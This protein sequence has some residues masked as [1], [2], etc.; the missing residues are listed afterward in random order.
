MLLYFIFNV[1]L[2]SLLSTKYKLYIYKIDVL[3]M[4]YVFKGYERVRRK[5]IDEGMS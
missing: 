3:F 2:S 5:R 4:L 1:Y